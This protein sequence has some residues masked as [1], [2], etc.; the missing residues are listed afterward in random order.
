MLK[1]VN[2]LKRDWLERKSEKLPRDL[3]N[4]KNLWWN[5]N[6]MIILSAEILSRTEI[7]LRALKYEK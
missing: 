7:T 1:C 6:T 3:C 5:L 2:Y 4:I